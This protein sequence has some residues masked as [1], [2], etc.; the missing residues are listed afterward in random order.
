[1]IKEYL[2][3]ANPVVQGGVLYDY[4][5]LESGEAFKEL[6][7]EALVI[8][9]VDTATKKSSVVY[10]KELTHAI[11]STALPP[12]NA[13]AVCFAIAPNT[14]ALEHLRGTVQ[15]TKGFH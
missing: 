12:Q 10:G 1:M 9:A 11:S 13:S 8:F 4:A 15:A 2:G 6:T 7:K 5:A 14:T 3:F